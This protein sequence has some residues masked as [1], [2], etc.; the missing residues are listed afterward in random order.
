[1][2]KVLVIPAWF[3]HENEASGIFISEFCEA[4]NEKEEIDITL[5]YIQF[6]FIRFQSLL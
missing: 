3:D 4:I 2:K 5:L 1:M 6:F